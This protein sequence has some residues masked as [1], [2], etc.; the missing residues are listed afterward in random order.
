MGMYDNFK[1]DPVREEEGVFLDYGDFRIRVAYAGGTNKKYAKYA[2][3]QLRPL[4]RAIDSGNLDNERAQPVMRDIY[5]KTIILGWQ[6]NIDGKWVDGIEDVDGETIEFNY[7]NVVRTLT[8]LPHLFFD[9][10]EQ[11]GKIVNFRAEEMKEE[12]GN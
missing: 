6:R 11:S 8:N 10:Q 3:A 9:I 5:A 2:E 7:D 12:L 4:R 1:T